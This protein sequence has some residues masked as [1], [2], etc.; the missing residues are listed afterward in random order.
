[1]ACVNEESVVAVYSQLG[2]AKQAL[3]QLAEHRI[4]PEHVSLIT[5]SL[6]D[7]EE[8]H[9]YLDHGDRAET[10]AARGAVVGGVLGILAGAAFFWI[11][12]FGP[13]IVLGPLAAG[14]TGG[15]VG[16]LIGA[17]T[18][19][20]IPK[21]RAHRYEKRVKAGDLLVVVHGDPLIVAQAHAVLDQTEPEELNLYIETSADAPE[22]DDS[23][24]RGSQRSS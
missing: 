13:L 18:G 5:H 7:E 24:L 10:D 4:S 11:P 23:P 17:M 21:E 20:G 6:E 1:M 3:K 19:W 8:L 16:A 14:L 2:Q 15:A 12:G 22:I 9:C